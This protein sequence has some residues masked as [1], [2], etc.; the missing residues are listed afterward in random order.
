MRK[1][2]LFLFIAMIGLFSTTS[3]AQEVKEEVKEVKKM[4]QEKVEVQLSELP[5]TVTA[6]ISENFAEYKAE[7][8]YK[9]SKEGKEVYWI[10]LEKDGQYI[11]AL[12][13]S[14]G[15]VIEQKEIVKS[16]SKLG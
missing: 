6:A 4:V 7:K 1:L 15:K 2:G 10:K 16:Q 11:K 5:E 9:G 12:I 3:F 14:E 8:A 13:D